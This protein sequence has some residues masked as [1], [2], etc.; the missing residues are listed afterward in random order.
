M[1][2]LMIQLKVIKIMTELLECSVVMSNVKVEISVEKIATD[3]YPADAYSRA[4]A[5]TQAVP[6]S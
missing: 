4:Q 1:L 5:V 3:W 2:A 6:P